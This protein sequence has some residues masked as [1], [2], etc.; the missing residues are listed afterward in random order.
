M[1]L[2]DLEQIFK[3]TDTLDDFLT[4]Q[5]HIRYNFVNTEPKNVGHT[6]YHAC[7]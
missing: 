4:S 6:T 5:Y 3:V 1:I 2:Y 7:I